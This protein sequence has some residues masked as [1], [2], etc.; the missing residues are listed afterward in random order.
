VTKFRPCIDLHQG[1]VKQIVGKSL[2]ED[3]TE[4]KTNFVSDQSAADFA[5][6]YAKDRLKGG[7]LIMLGPGNET[8][9]IEAMQAFS[10][11]LQVGGGISQDNASEWIKHGASHVIVT[12]CLFNKKGQFKLSR[13]KELV[14]RI[15]K[16]K[17]V[18]DLSCKRREN[19]WLVMKD[20]WQTE[21]DLLLNDAVLEM[22]SSYCD[23][24]LIHATDLEGKC[25]GIDVDL[26]KFLGN[27]SP[28]ASTYA[29]GVTSLEDLNFIKSI[30]SGKVDVTIGSG[31]DLFGG[32]MVKY[33]DCVSWNN[34][35]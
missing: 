33:K 8:V 7:H 11:G 1:R 35:N 27:Y 4:L 34:C 12:S 25:S 32:T 19:D 28:L 13:L 15:G 31:L 22:L 2:T 30:S 29:G 9:A 26:I 6:L 16:D 23:E 18:I 5:K 20:N 17:I 21:T 10:N 24:F 3:K 14:E